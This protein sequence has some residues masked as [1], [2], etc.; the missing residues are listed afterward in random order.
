MTH[1]GLY[2]RLQYLLHPLLLHRLLQTLV[3]DVQVEM[4]AC[5]Y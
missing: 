2:L 3:E 1:V 4:S 5:V